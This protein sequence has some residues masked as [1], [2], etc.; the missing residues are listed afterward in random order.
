VEFGQVGFQD[1][2]RVARRIAGYEDG[3]QQVGVFGG[4]KLDRRGHLV[5]FFGA[6]VGAVGEAEV[7]LGTPL[8]AASLSHYLVLSRFKSPDGSSIHVAHQE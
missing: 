8:V 1:R 5:E 3:A 7:D 4:E 6:D 2:R